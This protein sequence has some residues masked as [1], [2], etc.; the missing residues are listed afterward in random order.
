MAC[1]ESS[2]VMADKISETPEKS[3]AFLAPNFFT[4]SLTG[5]AVV[6]ANKEQSVCI[7]TNK[8]KKNSRLDQGASI[9]IV[10]LRKT[11]VMSRSN[12]AK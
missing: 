5:K 3:G 6:C 7:S 10:N 2:L 1:T 12:G 8:K 11:L 4:K 9:T